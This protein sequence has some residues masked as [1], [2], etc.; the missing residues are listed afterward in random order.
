MKKTISLFSLLLCLVIVNTAFAITINVPGDYPTIQAGINVAVTGDTIIVA[1]GVYHENI[2]IHV[3]NISLFGAGI[4]RTIID[5]GLCGIGIYAQ[6]NYNINITIEGFTVTNASNTAIIVT[7][8]GP[9]YSTVNAIIRNCEVKDNAIHGIAISSDFGG[10]SYIENNIIYN[11][12]HNGIACNLG[13]YYI[14]NNVLV[15]N[16]N[17]IGGWN[18]G[19]YYNLHNNIIVNNISYG[20]RDHATTPI[21]SYYNNIWG[22]GNGAWLNSPNSSTGDISFDPEFVTN[23]DFHLLS[24]SPCI[25]AGDPGSGYNDPDGSRND[26]G[27]YGGPE[28]NIELE[29]N[30]G[31]DQIALANNPVTLDGSGS[32]YQNGN[33]LTYNWTQD[34]SNPE[35]VVFSNNNSSTAIQT[36]FTPVIEGQYIFSLV[37]ND[38]T[39]DSDPDTAIINVR[40]NTVIH[41]PADYS[42]IQEGINNSLDG[43]SIIVNTGS[44]YENLSIF[45]NIFLIGSGADSTF[46]FPEE[47]NSDEIFTIYSD[48][49]ISGFSIG[50]IQTTYA[51]IIYIH[52]GNP[53]IK[54]NVIKSESQGGEWS[55]LVQCLDTSAP[56][57]MNNTIIYNFLGP[58]SLGT[59]ISV[60]S[61]SSP[62]IKNNLLYSNNAGSSYPNGIS[63]Y[64]DNY[65][66]AY[67]NIYGFAEN[68]TGSI[69]DLT[70]V[71]GNISA[72]PVFQDFDNSIYS[73]NYNSPC[74]DAGDPTSPYDPDSTINDMGC[75]PFTHIT[76][77]PSTP[78]NLILTIYENNLTLNWEI[79][80]TDEIESFIVYRSTSP[81]PDNE[82]DTVTYP[83]TQYIDT[84]VIPDTTYYYR[85][86]SLGNNGVTGYYSNEVYGA[87]H[88]PVLLVPENY[89]TIQSALDA[90]Y[91]GDLILVNDGT[92]VENLVWSQENNITLQSVNG[93]EVTVI[94]GSGDTES[95]IYV[96]NGQESVLIDGFTIINGYG[97]MAT[98]HCSINFGGGILIDESVSATIN[99][100]I[101][102][103]NGNT[104]SNYG[105]T[106]GGGVFVSL[107][108]SVDIESSVVSLNIGGNGGTGVSIYY[109]NFTS[110]GSVKNSL[111][112]DNAGS[113]YCQNSPIKI[114]NNTISN[115][116]TDGISLDNSWPEIRNNIISSNS[117]YA[118]YSFHADSTNLVSY[119]DIYNNVYGDHIKIG[120]SGED[121]YIVGYYGNISLDPFYVGGTPYDYHLTFISPCIDAGAPSSPLDPDGTIA[122]M[123]AFYFNQSGINTNFSADTTNGYV[124][125]QVNFTD[126]STP[127]D[128]ILS[129]QWDFQNDCVYDSF[130]QNPSFIYTDAGIYSVKLKVSD[131]T[132][133]DSLIQHNYITVEYVPLAPPTNVQINI[134]GN[135]AIISWN[136]VT[137]ANS[138]K[139][140]A[141]DKPYTGF[142][143]LATVTDTI[144]S[145][146]ITEVKKFYYVVASS[147]M[148]DFLPITS[149]RLNVTS[150]KSGKNYEKS[151]TSD[152]SVIKPVEE[153]IKKPIN[154]KAKI[155]WKK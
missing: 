134:S 7:T 122:D 84:N 129:W 99:N 110:E 95:C 62:V 57:I 88:N 120:I 132:N 114:L 151:N 51:S 28:A 10:T 148:R 35:V 127:Q 142:D 123:G 116:D 68:Y 87:P 133:V 50:Q 101:I 79:E 152:K 5:A 112:H 71:N 85:V 24:S 17:G 105:G 39:G 54:R 34:L 33:T 52:D 8:G 42:T 26:M 115:N 102:T 36:T 46:I 138:Y 97:S 96:G 61:T 145:T 37:V 90:V 92:Y 72:D 4:R 125:L 128:S 44:Y 81:F 41:I 108:S 29:A 78:T 23:S 155:E 143:S 38:G 3:N 103:G 98:F 48:C 69:P 47:G 130:I 135:D 136:A 13:S 16:N 94:D 121:I 55:Y 18:G 64:S 70:S 11:N 67:N 83:E 2:E 89:S 53:V 31:S 117:R 30:A 140:Y 59:A 107:G 25:N 146:S 60:Q 76:G 20:I 19:G 139:I 40:G 93:S 12:I 144:W 150:K 58:Y 91:D 109:R 119:N 153:S 32:S 14:Q 15:G 74:I 137:G 66:I 126:L 6:R 49:E 118:I 86:A 100:C 77:A 113:F 56:Q 104:V 9:I 1:E 73:L 80:P 63:C 149:K 43:D 131:G 45:N 124:P 154:K 75:F 82:I 27:N 106:Y 111:I 22:N 141:S 147:E 21:Y 65:E